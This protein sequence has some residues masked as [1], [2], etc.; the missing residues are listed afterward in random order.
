MIVEM[1]K[2]G[3]QEGKTLFG[4]GYDFRQSNRLQETM[5]RLAAKLESVYE[6]SG[7]KKI[8]VISHS[9]GGLLVKC[10]MGLHSD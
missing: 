3:F 4:F 1:L 10:F 8:N 6:A 5:D 9:M 7:G 2:W